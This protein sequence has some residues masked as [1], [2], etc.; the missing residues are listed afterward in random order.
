MKFKGPEFAAKYRAR[1]FAK[2]NTSTVCKKYTDEDKINVG[3]PSKKK[4]SPT[5]STAKKPAA[6]HGKENKDLQR[7]QQEKKEALI[8]YNIVR[9][10]CTLNL[11]LATF[12]RNLSLA[13]TFFRR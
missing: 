3:D 1:A 10:P 9:V 2:L 11:Q 4:S 8:A 12:N 5:R 6:I 7:Q 13:F